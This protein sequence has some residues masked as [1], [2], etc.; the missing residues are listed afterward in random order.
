MNQTERRE[1]RR[2]M[3]AEVANGAMCKAVAERYC[4]EPA[5]VQNACRENGVKPISRY[6]RMK[7]ANKDRDRAIKAEY[8]QGLTLSRIAG[9]YGISRQRVWKICNP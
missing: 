4:V 6:Q 3:A 7:Q 5:T 9:R 8:R 2:Q 1:R